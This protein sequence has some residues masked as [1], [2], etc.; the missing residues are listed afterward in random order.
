V[1]FLHESDG[2]SGALSRSWN[3]IYANFGFER[4][5]FALMLRPWYRIPE[6]SGNDDNPDIVDY[7]GHGD[8]VA[9]YK[10]G[11]QT[12]SLML[13]NLLHSDYRGTIELGYSFPLVGRLKGYVQ[14]FSGYGQSLLDYNHSQTTVGVGFMLTDWM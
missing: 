4:G 10:L 2:Q 11:E 7:M 13:R 14:L 1:G 6:N 9:V 8:V 3:R 5:N 12:F